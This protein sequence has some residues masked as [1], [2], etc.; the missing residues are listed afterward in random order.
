MGERPK[1]PFEL[2]NELLLKQ[3]LPD[4]LKTQTAKEPSCLDAVIKKEI[5]LASTAHRA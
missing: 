3:N 4:A 1:T 2:A 5:D